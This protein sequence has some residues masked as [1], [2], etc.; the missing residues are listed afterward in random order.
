MKNIVLTVVLL[1]SLIALAAC[2]SLPKPQPVQAQN[3]AA[4][5]IVVNSGKPAEVL[6]AFTTFS[7]NDEYSVV[8]SAPDEQQENALRAYIRNELIAY[9]KTKGYQY[10]PDPSQADVVIGFLFAQENTFADKT[11]QSKFGVLPNM[12]RKGVSKPGY[13]KGT[14]LLAVLNADLNKVYWR[15]ALQGFAGLETEM[16][17]VNSMRMQSILAVMLGGFPKA[18]S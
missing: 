7:W 1:I 2:S 11:T 18:G 12:Q 10:Q 14:L 5:M 4:R 17:D 15:S 3:N 13:K 9:L 8:L 6:P 16:Q